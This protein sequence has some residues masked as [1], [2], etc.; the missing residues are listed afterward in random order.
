M[1]RKKI[2]FKVSEEQK[3]VYHLAILLQKGFK[4]H[5]WGF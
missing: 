3:N 1:V 4:H 2:N 5:F